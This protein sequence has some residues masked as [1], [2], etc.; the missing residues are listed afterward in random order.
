MTADLLTKLAEKHANQMLMP[1]DDKKFLLAFGRE[2]LSEMAK[3]I[4][5]RAAN[6]NLTE[7]QQL[8][9]GNQEGAIRSNVRSLELKRA[10]RRLRSLA[11]EGK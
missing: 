2:L 4:E 6:W 11:G 1:I 9:V 8:S 3:E 7:T 10:A 5:T